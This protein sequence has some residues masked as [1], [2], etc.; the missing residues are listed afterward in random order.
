MDKIRKLTHAEAV[1]GDRFHYGEC[2]AWHGP[3]GGQHREIEEWRRTGSTQV[4]KTRPGDFRVPVKFGMRDYGSITPSNVEEF[5]LD[6]SC[7]L[8][9]IE[10]RRVLRDGTIIE[11]QKAGGGTLGRRYDGD[12][13]VEITDRRGHGVLSDDL[14]TGTPKTHAEVETL[15]FEFLGAA[16]DDS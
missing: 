15:A 11:I 13:H 12:W 10:Y 2:Q 9:D 1:N 8:G 4:W 14:Y 7:P 5:H 6:K 3:R 16:D